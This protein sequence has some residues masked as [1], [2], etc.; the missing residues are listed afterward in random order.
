MITLLKG[1]GFWLKFLF[2]KGRTSLQS[3][4]NRD[5]WVLGVYKVRKGE[6]HRMSHGMF[7]EVALG[8]CSEDD[9][10]RYEDDYGRD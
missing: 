10:T 3:H 9:I 8:E 7:F 4:R 5:E 2:V 6:V 1:K